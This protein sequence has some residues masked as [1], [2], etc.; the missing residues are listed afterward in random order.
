[1]IGTIYN[2]LTAN[3]S[4]LYH[5]NEEEKYW[6]I[7]LKGIWESNKLNPGKIQGIKIKRLAQDEN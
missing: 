6:V 7:L 2:F 5:V 1:M 4:I 3:N